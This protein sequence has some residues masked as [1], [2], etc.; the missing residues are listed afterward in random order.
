MLRLRNYQEEDARKIVSW[1]E[2]EVDFRRW[3]ADLFSKYPLTAE[4]LQEHYEKEKKSL[5]NGFLP[6]VAYDEQ[7]GLVGHLFMRFPDRD[8]KIVRFGFV[9]VD[10]RKRGQGYGK[11]MVRL[12]L[13]YA[14]DEL[15]AEKVTLGVF[16]N[17]LSAYYCYKVVGFMEVEKKKTKYFTIMG[18]QWKCLE[19]EYKKNK[20]CI[21]LEEVRA[22]IDRI[23]NDIIRLIAERGTYVK[24]ASKFKKNEE[25]V[26]AVSRVEKVIERVRKKAEEYKTNPDMV[27]AVYREMIKQFIHMELDEF[28]KRN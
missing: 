26:K 5:N 10:N 12:A 6:M 21:S 15:K 14:F 19:L 17:N 22:N 28:H 4:D 7:L 9:I 27:E 13:E 2:N 1:I 25:G 20:R 8:R 11:E 3:S 24:E 18:E 23:D 16:E